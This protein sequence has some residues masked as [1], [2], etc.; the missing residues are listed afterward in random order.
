[1]V[2]FEAMLPYIVQAHPKEITPMLPQRSGTILCLFLGLILLPGLRLFSGDGGLFAQSSTSGSSMWSFLSEGDF[3]P[4]LEGSYGY[5]IIDHK[6]FSADL[7]TAGAIGLKLGFREVKRFKSWGRKL[8]ERFIIG[9]YGS[10]TVPPGKTGTGELYGEWWRAGVGQR[11]GYGWEIGRQYLT[12]Y[13]QYS[14]NMTNM[15]FRSLEGLSTADTALVNRVT[16]KGRLSMSTEGGATVELFSTLS[17]SAGYE[18]TVVYTRMVFPEWIG[19]YLLLGSAVVV[20]S[21]YAEEIVASS[22]V[23]GPILYFVLRNAVAYG[24][25]YAFR[26]QMNWPFPSETPFMLHTFKI[27]VSLRF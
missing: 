23:L 1:M 14:F 16:G 2:A 21:S 9:T 8:D 26:T 12:P 3:E 24:F 13:H 5:G 15:K 27:D 17:A 19:S 4:I 10:S 18:A 22:P 20:M 11:S 6:L 7:P 25:F